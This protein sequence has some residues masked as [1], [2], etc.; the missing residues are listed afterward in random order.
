[1]IKLD[2]AAY[3][4]DCPNFYP[5]YSTIKYIH[6]LEVRAET[7]VFCQY[8]EGCQHAIHVNDRII[9]EAMMKHDKSEKE[10]IT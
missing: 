10:G 2:V 9:Q 3:C 4:Q 1:M 8:R 5:D 7:T 6:D